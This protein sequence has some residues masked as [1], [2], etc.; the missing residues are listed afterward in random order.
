MAKPE[1]DSSESRAPRGN[2]Y[3]SLASMSVLVVVVGLLLTF[4]LPRVLP[5]EMVRATRS[6]PIATVAPTPTTEP[7]IPPPTAAPVPLAYRLKLGPGGTLT[8]DTQVVSDDGL[9]VL[10]LRTGTRVTDAQG[11][12]VQSISVTTTR[13]QLRYDT[14]YVGSEYE[15][16][17]AGTTFDPPAS[18]TIR[19]D[20]RAYYPFLVEAADS[21]LVYLSYLSEN[22]A[23]RPA[24]AYV[25]RM[26]ASV[27]AQI[28]HPGTFVLYCEFL[29]PPYPWATN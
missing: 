10:G 13:P 9:A 5:D 23:V 29:K 8:E 21:G 20:T 26:I 3:V 4:A 18:I 2:K 15:F 6:G 22:G 17:P 19:Y 12:P 14:A 27:T 25:G 11:K 7:Y 24:L 16:R 28:D 1:L